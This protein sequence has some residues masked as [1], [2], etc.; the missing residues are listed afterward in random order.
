MKIIEDDFAER[1]ILKLINKYKLFK[2]VVLLNEQTKNSCNFIIDKLFTVVKSV[3]VVTF[4]NET[5][6][7]N[8]IT[9]IIT[10]SLT[11]DV[12]CIVNFCDDYV[13]S[14]AKNCSKKINII[15]VLTEPDINLF[16][17]DSNYLVVGKNLICN[18]SKKSV[19]NCYGK[20]CS[21][22]FYLIEQVFNRVVLEVEITT[23]KLLNLDGVLKQLLLVPYSVLKTNFG[24][25]LLI[26]FCVKITNNLE[27]EN[28]NNSYIK[29]LS[30]IICKTNKNGLMLEGE[31]LM[32]S[33]VILLKEMRVL[34]SAN[35][36]LPVGFNSYSRIRNYKNHFNKT[37][38]EDIYNSFCLNENIN[39]YAN[40]FFK[41]K[42]DF[43]TVFI[44]YVKQFEKLLN[45]FKLL[46]FDRGYKLSKT[47]SS[48]NILL[49]VNLIP[50]SYN[51]VSYAT[52]VRDVGL[53]NKL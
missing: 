35:E 33:S 31:R 25:M 8:V 10:D 13:L 27:F 16:L 52:F 47:V 50:E 26:K 22:L 3:Q 1:A 20:L 30:N 29:K 42:D 24:K 43:S 37:K 41:F 38:L 34:L 51:S 18:C 39:L 46:Y 48:Q 15:T 5:K 23:D 53:L 19:S 2:V 14:L 4:P 36:I 11:E 9:A 21:L 6:E 40:N 12:G 49:S 17:L 45:N 7:E 32:F 28:Y 44:Q